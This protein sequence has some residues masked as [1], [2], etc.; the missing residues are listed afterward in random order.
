MGGFL[1]SSEFVRIQ[2]R[3]SAVYGDETK[4]PEAKIIKEQ[5]EVKRIWRNGHRQQAICEGPSPAK[6]RSED[7][8]EN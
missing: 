7:K 8:K 1:P 5:T 6:L 2:L 3:W 4:S